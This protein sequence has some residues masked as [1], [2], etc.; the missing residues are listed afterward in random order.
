MNVFFSRQIDVRWNKK[1]R[2]RVYTIGDNVTPLNK[3]HTHE[4]IIHRKKRVAKKRPDDD[5]DYSDVDYL[6]VQGDRKETSEDEDAIYCVSSYD[7]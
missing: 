6:L 5:K 4:D 2:A 1:C 3:Y 7:N